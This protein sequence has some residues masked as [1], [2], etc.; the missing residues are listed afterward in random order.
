MGKRGW[1]TRG[2]R[3]E[4]ISI[5]PVMED[6]DLDQSGR[7]WE[8]FIFCM[9]ILIM[10]KIELRESASRWI[11]NYERKR[12]IG[13]TKDLSWTIGWGVQFPFTEMV[14]FWEKQIELGMGG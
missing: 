5:I 1:R 13:D 14:R 7:S 2:S 11:V 8:L 3:W 12:V 4:I 6:G 10:L 9:N